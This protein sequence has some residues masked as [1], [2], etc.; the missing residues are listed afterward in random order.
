MAWLK[1]V[2]KFKIRGGRLAAA[3][4]LV[5]C[6]VL[7]FS[8][9][10]NLVAWGA[11][12]NE[13]C[14]TYTVM[15]PDEETRERWIAAYDS[16]PRACVDG[17]GF[18]VP[19]PSGS[20]NLL[21]H[22][23]YTPVERDQG[24]CGNCWAWAGTA[25]LE[26]ALDVQEEVKDR[27]SVQYLHSC[28]DGNYACCGGWLSGFAD[29][30]D[31]GSGGSGQCIPW[32]NANASWQ[33]GS[34]S[35]GAGA[36]SVSCESIST[37]PDY[38]IFSIEDVTIET[39]TVDQATAI[40]NIKSVLHQDKAAW[41]G[42]FLPDDA[43]WLDFRNFWEYSGES[44]V[45]DID[46]FCGVPYE[47]GGGHAV[48]C[49]GY[50]DEDPDNSYWIM[51][52]SWGTTT[53]RPNGL[54]RVDMDMAYDCVNGPDYSFFWQALDVTF[55][56]MPDITVFPGSFN[57][58]LPPG[59]IW[60]DTL[61]IGNDGG[62]PLTYNITDWETTG[63]SSAL[64][65]NENLLLQPASMEL[66]TPLEIGLAETENAA[67]AGSGWQNIM[68]DD[69]EGAF[70]GMWTI[71]CGA[72]DAYW[73]KD[74]YNPHGG[75]YSAFC[76]KGGTE[77]VDPP[78]EYR[79]DMYSWMIYGPFSLEDAVAA[80]LSFSYW[81]DT[82]VDHDYLFC[83]ATVDGLDFYGWSASG[84]SGGWV[85]GE[86]DLTDVYVL[87]NLCGQS[88]VWVVFAFVSDASITYEGVFI[89]D[90][91]LRQIIPQ[92]CLWLD[93]SPISGSVGHGDSNNITVTINA[94][95]LAAAYYTAEII[96][97]SNDADGT[98]A[99]VPVN[100]HATVMDADFSADSGFPEYPTEGYTGVTQFNFS[101]ETG[102]G[103]PPYAY[104]WDFDNDAIVDS[105][106]ETPGYTYL[107]SGMYTVALTVGDSL[108]D[109]DT[110]IKVDYIMACEPGDGN[111]DG[112][113]DMGDVTRVERIIL[114]LVAPRLCADANQD[115][116]TDMGDV[117]KIE[118]IILGID[119]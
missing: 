49:A 1:E 102:G 101:G 4:H 38:P 103:T 54:F 94:T 83:G 10:G 118:R 75:L 44:A 106:D 28:K 60:S 58:T 22:L 21:N 25:C 104:E 11:S 92:D 26:I 88:H 39:Q 41:F 5:L 42:F 119:Q 116:F 50:D 29:F 45:Y 57:V 23:E 37:A 74:S 110:E 98:P 100:L 30:Y 81:M 13:R 2:F 14:E 32:S 76:A 91:A 31:P 85:D 19:S 16:A 117:T 115:G 79:N 99:I 93:E 89:D 65:S 43:A 33:D 86:L 34:S 111:G 8:V 52:N 73:G 95:G 51:L 61:S 27:L 17:E 80:D 105:T 6:L 20:L 69:F 67:E 71:Y 72:T 109:S 47:G 18:Q 64:M 53:D 55:G 87:G 48:L 97:A 3:I 7:A 90:V 56:A 70:P 78:A 15:H 68:T 112:F 114:E 66:P 82:Q 77:G 84:D 59:A 96:I 62:V 113:I 46:K 36:S 107:S 40:A 63:W 35:C 108:L 12:G 9:L 24:S